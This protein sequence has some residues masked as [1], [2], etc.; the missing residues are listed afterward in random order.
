[1]LTRRGFVKLIGSTAALA[2]LPACGDNTV[3]PSGL[4]LDEA[5]WETIDLCTE[6]LLP[7]ARDAK[8]VRYIDTLLAMFDVHP[9]KVFAGGPY[10]GRTPF[11]ADDGTKGTNF[12]DNSFEVFMPLSRVQDIAWRMRLMGSSITPG[13]DFNDTV[14]APTIGYRDLYASGIRALDA[15]ADGIAKGKTFRDLGTDDQVLALSTAGND[16]P[17]FYNALLEHTIEG[18]FAAPEYGGNADLSGWKF[19]RYDGDSAPLGHA[20]YVEATDQYVDRVDQP[21]STASPGDTTEQF[22]DDVIS[23]LT[24]AAV[25]SGGKRFF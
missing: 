14:L 11:P 23:L 5:S 18:T 2:Y 10:S 6:I 15:A 13:G 17:A 20:Q 8:A 19:A 7:G 3:H 1:M 25:G 21:T 9:A 22:D 4:V 24:V 12:P 16:I